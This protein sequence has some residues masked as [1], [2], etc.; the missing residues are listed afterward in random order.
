MQPRNSLRTYLVL[1]LLSVVLLIAW[2]IVR[3]LDVGRFHDE[4]I[5]YLFMSIGVIAFLALT[6]RRY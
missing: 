2:R 5:M 4:I 3:D 1:L 6:Y